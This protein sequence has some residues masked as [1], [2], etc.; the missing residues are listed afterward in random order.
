MREID[1]WKHGTAFFSCR[2]KKFRRLGLFETAD[3]PPHFFGACEAG[4]RLWSRMWYVMCVYILLLALINIIFVGLVKLNCLI[5]KTARRICHA[6]RHVTG[7]KIVHCNACACLHH[8]ITLN[9]ALPNDTWT[10]PN[11]NTHSH[12]NTITHGHEHL[13]SR[14]CSRSFLASP[15][16][17]CRCTCLGNSS[18]LAILL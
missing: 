4:M 6:P 16:S 5:F 15:P 3:G 1:G 12:Y 14:C 2:A 17:T 7:P 18:A 8:Q 13:H 9:R 11:P 10:N